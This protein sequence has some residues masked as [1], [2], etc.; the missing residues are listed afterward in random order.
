MLTCLVGALFALAG[1]IG[2][3]VA[4]ETEDERGG[5]PAR[6]AGEK[7]KVSQ[8]K[9]VEPVGKGEPKAL[10]GFGSFGKGTQ[11]GKGK[12]QAISG[13]GI[14]LKGTKE[15]KGKT[16]AIPCFGTFGKGTQEGAKEIRPSGA[17]SEPE[18]VK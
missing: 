15:D 11:E 7:E 1:G 18:A 13:R 8:P 3:S 4:A 16:Q 14:F 2:V 9:Q 6:V 5:T 12:T 17:K 10:V